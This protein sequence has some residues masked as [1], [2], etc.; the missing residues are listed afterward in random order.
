MICF[1]LLW[2]WETRL[3]NP[4]HPAS[5]I[6]QASCPINL[7]FFDLWSPLSAVHA[8][9]GDEIASLLSGV[10]QIPM[11]CQ[12]GGCWLS[13]GLWS[14][15]VAWLNGFL[16]NARILQILEDRR[17]S[18]WFLEP[19]TIFLVMAT[20]SS[21]LRVAAASPTAASALNWHWN[22]QELLEQQQQQ[23]EKQLELPWG[24]PCDASLVM[25]LVMTFLLL[26]PT[27]PMLIP[28]P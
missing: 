26:V 9:V 16:A 7:L 14:G 1:I 27:V 2:G 28:F 20:T 10:G 5:W 24:L 6:L 22:W 19:W 3:G 18:H 23:Q 13:L 25:L 12:L 15:S 11:P 21:R 17:E 8:M 4:P